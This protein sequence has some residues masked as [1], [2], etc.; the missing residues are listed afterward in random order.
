MKA[1]ELKTEYL[2]N[3]LAIDIKSPKLSWRATEGIR[4]TAY[5]ITAYIDGMEVY[6]TGKV[7][8]SRIYHR[9]SGDLKSRNKVI[10]KVRLWDEADTC[11]EWSEEAYFEMGLLDEKDWKA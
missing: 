6:D 5:Q 8:D 3:P 1:V 9:Y 2:R 4:Q 11:G 7:E 10:W